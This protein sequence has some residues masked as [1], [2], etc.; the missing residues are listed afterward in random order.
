MPGTVLYATDG[1]DSS[2]RALETAAQQLQPHD[3]VV[4]TV[5]HSNEPAAAGARAALPDEVIRDAIGKLDDAAE[6]QALE[7]ATA[8]A[9]VLSDRGMA[10]TPRARRCER[11]V[12][13]TILDTAD[14]LDAT[15]IVVG[16]RGHSGLKAALLGSVSAGIVNHSDRPVVVVR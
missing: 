4:M 6:Q 5:W 9:A 2:L 8:G 1:S 14:E 3:A 7:T 15:A 13:S 11:N 12:W 16:S 10:A